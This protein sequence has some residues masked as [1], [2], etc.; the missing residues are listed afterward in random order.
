MKSMKALKDAIAR[1]GFA[2]DID[3]DK[4]GACQNDGNICIT[5]D[6]DQKMQFCATGAT[7][8][9][10]AYYSDLPGS[11]GE[12]IESLIKDIEFGFEPMS[13]DTADACGVDL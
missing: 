7:S 8:C 5:V 12:A 11:R 10:A 13:Q 6:Q 4:P 1:T 9:C 3:E 2:I